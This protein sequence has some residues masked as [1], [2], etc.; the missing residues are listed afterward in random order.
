MSKSKAFY[1]GVKQRIAEHAAGIP[2]DLV[3]LRKATPYGTEQETEAWL[4][5]YYAH[6][7]LEDIEEE[8]PDT[9]ELTLD[10]THEVYDKKDE[11]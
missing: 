7:D 9:S 5:G 3:R 6:A 11:L 1:A 2:S 8:S 4:E 10:E